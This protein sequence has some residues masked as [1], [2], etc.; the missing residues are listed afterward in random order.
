MATFTY[1]YIFFE[2][3]AWTKISWHSFS[4][5]G[6]SLQTTPDTGRLS[7]LVAFEKMERKLNT[8]PASAEE[9]QSG[10]PTEPN[11][12]WHRRIVTICIY[13]GL[14]KVKDFYIPLVSLQK[15]FRHKFNSPAET[16]EN[17]K[18]LCNPSQR[19]TLLRLQNKAN[20]LQSETQSISH[21]LD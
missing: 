18:T 7:Q 5:K 11:L 20:G 6:T 9:Q 15:T 17:L 21:F 13:R 10:A 3:A 12:M 2:S 1:F 19:Q 16:N 4:P 14:A 8:S